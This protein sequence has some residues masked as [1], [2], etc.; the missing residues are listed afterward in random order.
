MTHWPEDPEISRLYRDMPDVA[1]HPRL[2]SRIL[3]VAAD[4][5]EAVRKRQQ[6]KNKPTA[7]AALM[8]WFF[9]G[10]QLPVGLAASLMVFVIGFLLVRSAPDEQPGAVVA[11][12]APPAA[13]PSVAESHTESIAPPSPRLR[14][15]VVE[16]A[17]PA[18][19]SPA[20]D[21][22]PATP[23]PGMQADD[24]DAP[25]AQASGG[26][27][28]VMDK[29][30]EKGSAPEGVKQPAIWL[31]QIRTLHKQ[32][33]LKLAKEQMRQFRRKYPD[34][35]LPDDLKLLAIRGL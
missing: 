35:P 7:I 8:E 33:N 19:K 23:E 27:P 28:S 5:A 18:F 16:P 30:V 13:T 17:R 25:V 32:G 24:A 34:Y 11:Q 9:H 12:V 22:H 31:E 29:H 14:M 10:W 2:K 26:F 6:G 21:E 15:A 4:Q 1:P 20:R 3:D